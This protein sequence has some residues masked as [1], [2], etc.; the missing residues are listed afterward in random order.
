MPGVKS[1]HDSDGEDLD[2]ETAESEN[3][4]NE[5]TESTSGSGSD[6]GSSGIISV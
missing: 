2:Q 5:D 4:S 1:M 3:G 6:D